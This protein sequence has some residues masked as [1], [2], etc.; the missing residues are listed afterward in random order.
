MTD[1]KFFLPALLILCLATTNSCSQSNLKPGSARSY[2][3]STPCD[4]FI[5]SS[6]QIPVHEN[7]EFIKWEV[8]FINS[9]STFHL[10]A[11]HGEGQPNTNGFK[12]GG[13]STRL[14]GT[15]SI[16][17]GTQTNRNAKI[18]Y[19][20]PKELPS[21]LL[22]IEMDENVFH[23]LDGNKELLVGNGGW[24]YVLNKVQN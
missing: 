5:K 10:T 14:T 24:G 22:L 16:G 3:G 20:K 8:T 23:F 2:V 12:G 7:C 13:T 9:D 1:L 18:Y 21:Q 11:L 4:A 15:Y 6:L 17:H 19:L